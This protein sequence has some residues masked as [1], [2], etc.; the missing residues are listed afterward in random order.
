[1]DK[2]T[3]QEIESIIEDKTRDL[4]I[5]LNIDRLSEESN[6]RCMILEAINLV[7][8]VVPLNRQNKIESIFREIDLVTRDILNTHQGF[9]KWDYSILYGLRD[10]DGT[11]FVHQKMDSE[12]FFDENYISKL[13]KDLKCKNTK[14]FDDVYWISNINL[15]FKYN[16]KK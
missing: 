4:D 16:R 9:S 11:G 5:D 10:I 8:I 15:Y 2:L 12:S 3:S 14:E 7:F 13:C 1:M 6:V